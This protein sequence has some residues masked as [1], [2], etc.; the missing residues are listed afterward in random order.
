MYFTKKQAVLEHRKMWNWI[1]QKTLELK[2]VVSKE[3]YLSENNISLF[4]LKNNCFCCKYDRQFVDSIQCP[5]NHCPINWGGTATRYMCE[6]EK[7]NELVPGNTYNC[8][9]TAFDDGNYKLAAELAKKIAELP[10]SELS[11]QDIAVE[12]ID[13]LD[14]NL[15]EVICGLEKIQKAKELSLEELRDLCWKDSNAIF[16]MIYN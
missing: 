2:Q 13:G 3:D 15:D 16:D 5:C 10:E 12:L 8:W 1:A 9:I 4:G 11:L 7:E 6:D 14:N